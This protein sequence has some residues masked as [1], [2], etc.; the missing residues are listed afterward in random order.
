MPF[1]YSNKKESRSNERL[2]VN[3]LSYN[4]LLAQC[5]SD[6]NCDSATVLRILIFLEHQ[7]LGCTDTEKTI[8]LACGAE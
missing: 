6:I 1:Q 8:I 2:S 3:L 5:T 4:K 7:P